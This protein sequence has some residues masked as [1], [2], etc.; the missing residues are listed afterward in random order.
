MALLAARILRNYPRLNAHYTDDNLELSPRIDLGIAVVTDE[1]LV[2]LCS[3]ELTLWRKELVPAGKDLVRL[4]RKGRL[5][6]PLERRVRALAFGRWRL[7]LRRHH[8][9]SK[10]SVDYQGA[11]RA[12]FLKYLQD[13]TVPR[14]SS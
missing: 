2:R 8:K 4:T 9:S 13:P 10:L 1:G 3:R 7:I 12:G 11:D 6:G 14:G 5:R